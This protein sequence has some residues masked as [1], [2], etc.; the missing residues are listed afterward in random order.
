MELQEAIQDMHD[1]LQRKTLSRRVKLAIL[2][3]PYASDTHLSLS[4]SSLPSF[5]YR[6]PVD[7]PQFCYQDDDHLAFLRA[8]G[9][10]VPVVV[11]DVPVQGRWDPQYFIDE[12]GKLPVTLVN[13]ETGE[14]KPA[15][16]ADFFRGFLNPGERTG[17]WKLK[18]RLK[19]HLQI[20]L[21]Q[22]F[23]AGLATSER[24]PHSV[25]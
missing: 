20:S 15:K 2:N 11:T 24:L 13:C 9:H 12:Y 1:T 19:P 6:K 18:V 10:S 16:V 17:I 14:T 4:P 21:V 23:L 3:D 8:L 5:Q 25:S 22:P 7:V